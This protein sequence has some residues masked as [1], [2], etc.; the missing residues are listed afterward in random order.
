MR[1]C[2]RACVCVCGVCVHVRL[3]ARARVRVLG[4][5]CGGVTVVMGR[6]WPTGSSH[7]VCLYDAGTAVPRG[8]MACPSG[9]VQA[10]IGRHVPKAPCCPRV[11]EPAFVGHLWHRPVRGLHRRAAAGLGG[12]L[13]ALCGRG[14]CHEREG[15]VDGVPPPLSSGPAPPGARGVCRTLGRGGGLS[16]GPSASLGHAGPHVPWGNMRI[17]P[18]SPLESARGEGA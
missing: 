7:R 10:R 5:V 8:R 1:L 3:C 9:G 14:S 6:A 17:G 13:C 18:G 12:V 2:A 4:C 11:L 15:G 16:R